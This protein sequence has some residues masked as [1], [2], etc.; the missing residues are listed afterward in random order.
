MLHLLLKQL[1]HSSLNLLHTCPRKYQLTKLCGRQEQDS[2][3]LEFG[4]AVGYGIQQL[5]LGRSV[6]DVF[7][8]VFLGWK[9]DIEEDSPAINRKKKTIWHA[10]SAIQIFERTHLIQLNNHYEVATFNEVPAVELG[11]RIKI[12][13]DY[14]YRG[15]VD[16]VLIHKVKRELLVV[17]LKTTAAK[18]IHEAKFA[19]SS[20]GLG[21]SLIC[22]FIAQQH[23]DVIASSY[24]ILYLVYKTT[25]LEY[26]E[27]FFSKSHSQRAQWI[28]EML[29]EVDT[30]EIYDREDCFPMHGESCESW[31]RPCDFFGVCNLSNDVLLKNPPT[32][33]KIEADIDFT[34][35]I[36]LIE[37][38]EAQ[39]LRHQ[40]PHGELTNETL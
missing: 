9:R 8:D 38:I 5:L 6:V 39:L 22:D 31:G 23:P 4:K 18:Y 40:Q 19:N 15:F 12:G 35:N 7:F 29:V 27:M 36:S 10:L 16:V 26:E 30:M 21:Y 2:E 37:L 13:A 20:Q 17:E 34:F 25:L 28:K 33:Y 14:Y 11:F 1:S 3:D 24:R 32:D